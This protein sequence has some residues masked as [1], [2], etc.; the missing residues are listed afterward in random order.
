MSSFTDILIVSPLPDGK[1]WITRSEFSYDVGYKG[2]GDTITV[3]VGFVTD[4]ASI[5]RI[6]WMLLPTWGKYGNAAVIHD[7]LY[8]TKERSR[9]EADDIFYEGMLVLGTKKI[10]AKVIYLAVRLFGQSAYNSNKNRF[11]LIKEEDIKIPMV[12]KD[13]F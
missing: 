5:P 4:F 9:K 2:S 6:F 12:D 8:C 11:V 13:S 3:P 1:R 7:Y 10:T